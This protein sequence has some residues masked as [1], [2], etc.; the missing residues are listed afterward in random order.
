M[1]KIILF[2]V[3]AVGS[4]NFGCSSSMSDEETEE[5]KILKTKYEN[6]KP[7]EDSL[8]SVLQKIPLDS[9]SDRQYT[10]LRDK[11]LQCQEYM[12]FKATEKSF[13][14]VEKISAAADLWMG[15]V[16]G[17]ALIGLV[18]LVISAGKN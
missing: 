7:C 3:I 14:N 9:L 16:I 15:L 17:G 2:F 6:S 4:I 11:E 12:R 1:N 18:V 8:Y 13:K 5:Y 10:Y